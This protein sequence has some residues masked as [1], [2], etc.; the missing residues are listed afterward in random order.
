M[1]AGCKDKELSI[2]GRSVAIA[3]VVASP[4]LFAKPISAP[5][6]TNEALAVSPFLLFLTVLAAGWLL[7]PGGRSALSGPEAPAQVP[8]LH[9]RVRAVELRV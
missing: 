5:A 3:L 1:E 7:V 9:A 2:H 6:P 8:W 4:S